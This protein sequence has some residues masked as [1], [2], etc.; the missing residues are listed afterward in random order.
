[1]LMQLFPALE[2]KTRKQW[3]WQA[4]LNLRNHQMVDMDDLFEL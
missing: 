4:N 3:Y 2:M 1:M